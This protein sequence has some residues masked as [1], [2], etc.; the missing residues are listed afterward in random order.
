MN[1]Y[2]RLFI[3]FLTYRFKPKLPFGQP[4]VQRRRV[5]PNDID[6]NGHVN[7]GRYLT[8]VDLATMEMFLR[9]GLLFKMFALGWRPMSGGSIVSYRR[10]LRPFST[11]ELHFCLDSWDERWNY[12]RYE[13]VQ[14]GQTAAVGFFKAA[15]VGRSGWI[16]NTLVGEQFGLEREPFQ[17]S[18]PVKHWIAADQSLAQLLR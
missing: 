5:W 3:L 9:T 13:F 12:L 7:N 11:Y 6:I 18:E 8:L 14:N 17:L 15:L 2:F 10:G 4:L 16:S 1:L